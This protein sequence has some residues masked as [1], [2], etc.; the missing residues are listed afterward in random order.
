MGTTNFKVNSKLDVKVEKEKQSMGKPIWIL[1]I[2]L[3]M[4]VLMGF[5]ALY[6]NYRKDKEKTYIKDPKK[7]DVYEMEL[8]NGYF[9]TAKVVFVRNDSIFVTYNNLKTDQTKGISEI[10]IERNYGIFKGAY[11][12]KK[13]EKLF[14]QDSIFAINRD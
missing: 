11:S 3:T 2:L 7:G 8:K 4:G 13:I 14:A 12:K 1:Y 6:Y 5:G 9:S 10:D